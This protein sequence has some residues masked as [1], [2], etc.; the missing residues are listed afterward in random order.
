MNNV[1]QNRV[2]ATG[3]SF[4]IALKPEKI[5]VQYNCDIYPWMHG[6][7]LVSPHPYAAVSDASGNFTINGLPTGE[8]EFQ[9]WHERVGSLKTADWPKGRFTLDIKHGK[10]NL[11]TIKLKPEVLEN[12]R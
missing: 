1:N 9:V 7:I 5:P 10:N 6:W 12:R 3:Q 8:W 4:E 2:V 11:G